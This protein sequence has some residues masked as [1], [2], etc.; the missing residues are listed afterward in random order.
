[1]VI[2]NRME[3][4][5]FEHRLAVYGR[6]YRSAGKFS[7]SEVRS[8]LGGNPDLRDEPYN[9]PENLFIKTLERRAAAKNKAASKSDAE[10]RREQNE[11]HVA[12]GRQIEADARRNPP[13]LT[14]ADLIER[15]IKISAQI[16]AE[17]KFQALEKWQKNILI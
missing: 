7:A 17:E 1:M 9:C 6:E 3:N 8:I 4:A 10:W 5:V 13:V 2:E 12:I 15:S 11:R 16:E 14:N